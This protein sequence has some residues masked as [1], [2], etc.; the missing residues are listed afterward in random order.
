[1]VPRVNGYECAPFTNR[2]VSF[3]RPGD[4][5]C[6]SGDDMSVHWSYMENYSINAAWFALANLWNS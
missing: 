4:P 5:V 6:D 2:I 3:C 1:M